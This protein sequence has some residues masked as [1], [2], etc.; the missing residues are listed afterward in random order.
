MSIINQ[1]ISIYDLG[2][3]RHLSRALSVFEM[4]ENDLPMPSI[5][6]SNFL[7]IAPSQMGSGELVGNITMV[8][9][10]LQSYNFETGVAGWQINYDGD[11]EFNSGVFRGSLV[12]GSIHIPDQDTTVNSS[13]TDSDGN[14]WW[15]CTET[16]FTTDNDNANAY[17]LKT[18][19]AKLQSATISGSV[20]ITGGSGIASLSDAGALA[21]LD[22]VGDAQFSGTLTVG[23]TEAKC[24]DANADQT[25]ANSQNVAWLTDAGAMAYEDLV[26]VAK[27]GTTIVDGGYIKTSLIEAGTVVAGSVAAE[28]I[29]GT[30][31][32]GII[33]KT[34]TGTSGHY[35][36]I[37]LTS[38]LA[39]FYNTDN[40]LCGQIYG[41]VSGGTP[42]LYITAAGT[43]P[44]LWLNVPAGGTIGFSA[45]GA[46]QAYFTDSG[47]LHIPGDAG[48]DI[49]SNNQVCTLDM[50]VSH[51]ITDDLTMYL[52][53]TNVGTGTTTCGL[54]FYQPKDAT[55]YIGP[56]SSASA[57]LG[58]SANKFNNLYLSGSITVGGTVDGVDIYAHST[59]ASAH[60]TKYT[61]ANARAA[62][63]NY[64]LG[65]DLQLNDYDIE[66]CDN[67][68]V[69][70]IYGNNVTEIDVYESFD[71][72]SNNLN[73]VD[74]ISFIANTGE[75][76]S[77]GQIQ[78]YA[79]GGTYQF[80]GN[81]GGWKGS[82]D[83]SA[84]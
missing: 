51:T 58:S 72:N 71:M 5:M 55:G 2:F 47:Y 29:T 52:Y 4:G 64:N 81:V 12:A 34:D 50:E 18:G 20:T 70:D 63:I 46:I 9:G 36:R 24:T 19:V 26:E 8:A 53:A 77:A 61:D 80:R 38:S 23:K 27:L 39:N 17:I 49:G 56:Y 67:L 7:E 15:G 73:G 33:I 59:N 66:G 28:D 43:N 22:V 84:T 16:N 65:G 13:H 21:V 11:V 76:A 14:S 74:T 31:I 6:G 68:Y 3:N 45:G 1:Q 42:G 32:T 60:H 54:V 75:P 44:D 35:Q 48:L 62:I 82:F 40:T 41:Y 37:E 69:D 79:S 30:T 78:Y 25:S 10:L 57:S 83:M